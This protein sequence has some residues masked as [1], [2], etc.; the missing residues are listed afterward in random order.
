MRSVANPFFC[1][2]TIFLHAYEF[3]RL[4][5]L[6]LFFIFSFLFLTFFLH[7]IFIIFFILIYFLS[8][9]FI[10]NYFQL[11]SIIFL[12]LQHFQYINVNNYHSFLITSCIG[13]NRLQLINLLWSRVPLGASTS[14]IFFLRRKLWILSKIFILIEPD[15]TGPNR[16]ESGKV[17]MSL[18]RM[19]FLWL[20]LIALNWKSNKY[21]TFDS[22]FALYFTFRLKM[23]V[24][25]L[26]SFTRMD[27]IHKKDLWSYIRNAITFIF[28]L[29]ERRANPREETI[30]IRKLWI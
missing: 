9:E 13:T 12:Y 6:F 24:F 23:I 11:F 25:F 27:E 16:N 5:A 8:F 14:D 15:R 22:Q 28:Y 29:F 1:T 7:F 21:H 2:S 3:D 18:N 17:R 19:I 10:F 30:C 20:P 26:S 4:L